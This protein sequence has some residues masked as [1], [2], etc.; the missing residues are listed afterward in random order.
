VNLSHEEA[1]EFAGLYALDALDAE[2]RAGVDAHLAS[3]ELDHSEFAEVGGV[4]PALISLVEPVDAPASLKANVMAAYAREAAPAPAP[5]RMP[6]RFSTAD[7]PRTPVQPAPF[8]PVPLQ[9]AVDS[10]PSRGAWRMPAWT[11]WA[12]AVAAVLILAVVGGYALQANSRATDAEARA[13]VMSDAVAAFAAPGSMTA[14]LQTD[15][16]AGFAAITPSGETYVVMTGMDEAPVGHDYQA[17][18][19]VDGAP[20]SAGLMTVYDDGVAILHG[21]AASEGVQAVALSVEPVG[22]SDQPTTD[23]IVVGEMQTA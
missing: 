14:T 5:A 22:G 11:G 15:G 20:V 7:S 8:Q 10:V 17:W 18:Y 3:C 2:E 6:G 9:P 1:L 16:S 23:P 13:A 12:T 19:I 4:A 21:D